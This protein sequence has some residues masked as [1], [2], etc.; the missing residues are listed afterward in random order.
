MSATKTILNEIM[1]RVIYTLL[2]VGL[3]FGLSYHF[4]E[5]KLM[6]GLIPIVGLFLMISRVHYDALETGR[7][8]T[9][10]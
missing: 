7:Q 1:L 5:P 6:L 2:L 9:K 3:I 8:N 4:S 10:I